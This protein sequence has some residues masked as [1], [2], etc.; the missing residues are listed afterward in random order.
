MTND[1]LRVYIANDFV[2]IK[3]LFNS[4]KIIIKL[5]IN[6]QKEK[7]NKQKSTIR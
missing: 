5:I 6:G 1:A 2:Y 3:K 7:I 4:K